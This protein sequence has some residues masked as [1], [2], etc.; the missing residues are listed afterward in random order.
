MFIHP[1]PMGQHSIHTLE[2]RSHFFKQ[3]KKNACNNFHIQ[4]QCS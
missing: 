1:N 3:S 2:I 4:F